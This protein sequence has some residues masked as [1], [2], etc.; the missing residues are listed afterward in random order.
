MRPHT[1]C[2]GIVRPVCVVTSALVRLSTTGFRPRR[3][4]PLWVM[5]R[6]CTDLRIMSY[7][8]ISQLPPVKADQS[9]TACAS[10]RSRSSRGAACTAARSRERLRNRGGSAS[11]SSARPRH[12]PARCSGVPTHSLARRLLLCRRN[13]LLESHHLCRLLTR[14]RGK[15]PAL[16]HAPKVHLYR[17]NSTREL[18]ACTPACEARAHAC[19]CVHAGG[20]LQS[21]DSGYSSPECAPCTSRWLS[22]HLLARAHAARRVLRHVRRDAALLRRT[23]RLF[24]ELEAIRNGEGR[25]GAAGRRRAVVWGAFEGHV[26][27]KR[28]VHVALHLPA[29][30][31]QRQRH[32]KERASNGERDADHGACGRDAGCARWSSKGGALLDSGTGR[33]LRRHE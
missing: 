1:T 13:L 2:V 10:A 21:A 12:I 28:G 18:G 19:S 9:C 3:I 25:V 17:V 14:H 32:G 33:E 23:R 6:L 16:G 15:A 4:M 24:A 22:A 27:A 26:A 31:L 20:C 30:P 29:V 8:E 5:Q 7:Q 11:S